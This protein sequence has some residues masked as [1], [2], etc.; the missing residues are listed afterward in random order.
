MSRI[1]QFATALGLVATIVAAPAP[2]SEPDGFEGVYAATGPDGIGG[3]YNGFVRITRHGDSFLVAWLFPRY[4]GQASVL[5]IASMGVGI[6][7]EGTL[8]VSYYGAWITGVALY[9]TSAD[10]RLSGTWTVATGDGTVYSETLTRLSAGT[11]PDLAAPKVP[12]A[13]V[14]AIRPSGRVL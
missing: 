11:A 5:E 10:G 9:R 3:A 2:A 12:T 4:E 7:S 14:I 6:A 1:P 13:P 8:A